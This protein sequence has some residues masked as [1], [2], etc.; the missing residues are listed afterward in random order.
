ML[1][2]EMKKRIDNLPA[3]IQGLAEDLGE[4][5]EYIEYYFIFFQ[6]VKKGETITEED[7]AKVEW[8]LSKFN[9]EDEKK[10]SLEK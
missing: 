4:I 5:Q 3:N 9:D 2:E 6:R 1:T 7:I 8:L 10:W